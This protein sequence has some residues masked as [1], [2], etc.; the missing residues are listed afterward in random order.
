[1]TLPRDGAHLILRLAHEYLRD[2]GFTAPG[3]HLRAVNR[4]P[5]AR[6]LGSSAAAV[7]AA[8][9]AAEA[10]LPAALRRAP[11]DLLE[12]ATRFEGHPDNVA[13]AL[14][15]GATVSWTRDDVP[16][17]ATARL[18]L[19]E[20]VVPVVAIPDTE[21]STH[22]AR[23]VLPAE[24]PHAVAAAQAG[25]AALLVHALAEDPALLPAA[26]RDWLHQE[27]RAV[28]MPASAALVAGLR[29]R[30][31]AAV[32]S[33]AGPTVLALC[34]GVQAAEHAAEAARALT[35][36]G[37]AAWRVLVPCVAVD[38]VRVESLHHG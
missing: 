5:H 13:P 38:G 16:G 6:G 27:P 11:A 31:H 29:E 23:G 21:L 33:G 7:V 22:V 9:A 25:R 2:R 14:V 26:T 15:G 24:V 35:A 19:H 17:P 20:R 4:I 34:D 1:A 36:D 8:Y 37:A 28:T 10:L 12:A 3:L 18:R 32:V 30:G